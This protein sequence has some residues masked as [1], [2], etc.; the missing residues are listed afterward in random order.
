YLFEEM[1]HEILNERNKQ[2]VFDV[3]SRW[4]KKYEK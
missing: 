3:V 4:L 1:R 2:Q